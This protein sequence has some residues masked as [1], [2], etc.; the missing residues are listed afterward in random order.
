MIG[1][2]ALV[3]SV[4]DKKAVV[5]APG[6]RFVEIKNRDFKVGQRILLAPSLLSVTDR[7][8]IALENTKE[9]LTRLADRLRYKGLIV[10]SSLAILIPS[11]GYAAAKFVP[12]TYVSMDTGSVSLQYQVN[13]LGEV[14]ST[15]TLSD[16][17]AAV[18]DELPP[19]RYEKVEN[20]MDRALR[21]IY[22]DETSQTKEPEPVMIG[23]STRFGSGKKTLDTI[24]A[25]ME[26]MAPAEISFK[27][28]NW[29]ETGKAREEEIS[30]GQ[31]SR[32]MEPGAHPDSDKRPEI[33][34]TAP[35]TQPAPEHSEER[36][37]LPE[38]PEGPGPERPD[39]NDPGAGKG[40]EIMTG[41]QPLHKPEEE[42]VGT[43]EDR[44]KFFTEGEVQ[45][46]PLLP[47][48]NEKESINGETPGDLL[49][50]P[51]AEPEL[52]V[53]R[54]AE[55]ASDTVPADIPEKPSESGAP[56][57]GEPPSP[58]T[59]TMPEGMPDNASSF[60]PG[61]QDP[62]NPHSGGSPEGAP[63]RK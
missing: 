51:K 47:F 49:I 33:P 19:V 27:Q 6:G 17:A 28:L 3:M 57:G 56:A 9:K 8:G 55:P 45:E 58:P 48:E 16:D 50:A 14:L 37:S 20:A 54:T 53:E 43:S 23:I 24:A 36:P 38:K 12:W 2:F 39:A 30:I 29:S 11:S 40:D 22:T 32:R 10:L 13:A 21:V 15:E 26:P 59:G 35:E 31:Y 42:Q 1:E 60:A 63:E 5:L 34:E 46:Y 44:E 52:P 18:V 61:P 7:A 41:S 62:G 4:K 25:H